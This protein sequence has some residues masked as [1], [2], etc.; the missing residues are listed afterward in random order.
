METPAH[1]A[2]AERATRESNAQAMTVIR[3]GK[4]TAKFLRDAGADAPKYTAEELKII[5]TP[6]DFIGLNTYT[7]YYVAAD[8]T[9][10]DSYI[11][12]P[13]PPSYPHMISPWL[14]V[15]PEALYWGSRHVTKLW[16]SKPIYITEN[17]CSSSD[18]PDKDGK[19]MD[20]DRVMYLRNYL[21]Q[22]RRAAVEGLPVSGYF[23][24]SLMDNFEWADGYTNRF[25]LHYVDYATQ[26]RTPKLSANYY[27]EVIARNSVL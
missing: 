21:G 23:L 24:W 10:P 18:V 7:G 8:P 22:L 12:V 20:T 13:N 5:S 17:G 4:Y 3:E 26:T 15:C 1:I 25:G 9:K 19:V 11:N 2:A 6:L 14:N 16:G 27:R